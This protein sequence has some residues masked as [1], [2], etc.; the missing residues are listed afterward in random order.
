M[1]SWKKPTILQI[2]RALV[3]LAPANQK[4]NERRHFYSRLKNPT[5][6]PFLIN[7]GIYKNPPAK[8]K[9]I[10]GHI[11]YPLW[12]EFEYLKNISNEVPADVVNIIKSLQVQK[13]SKLLKDICEIASKLDCI[14]LSLSLKSFVFQLC[15][16]E[17]QHFL[18]SP[19][20]KILSRWAISTP[21]SKN[22]ALKLFKKIIIFRPAPNIPSE[23]RC[24]RELY[25][26][27]SQTYRKQ[28]KPQPIVSNW[29]YQEILQKGGRVLVEQAPF[30]CANIIFKALLQLLELTHC[31]DSKTGYDTS[32]I[33]CE[34][35]DHSTRYSKDAESELVHTMVYACELIF[36]HHKQKVSDID[37]LL[38]SSNWFLFRRIR[39]HLFAKYPDQAEKEWF[40][41]CI[42]EP[43]RNYAEQEHHYEFQR[44]LRIACQKYGQAL[45][46][47]NELQGYLDTILT[48]P[49][50]QKWIEGYKSWN[51]IEPSDKDFITR[52][53]YFHR[54][55]LRP[56]ASVLY[57][58][59]KD[60]YASLEA[61]ALKM[62]ADPIT[63][64]DYHPIPMR[65]HSVQSH[66]PKSSHDMKEMSDEDLFNYLQEWDSPQRIYSPQKGTVEISHSALSSAF[67]IHFIE[68]ISHNSNR[69]SWWLKNAKTFHRPIFCEAIVKALTNLVEAKQ[70]EQLQDV[71]DFCNWVLSYADNV[72]QNSGSEERKDADPKKCSWAS[73]RS[74]VKSFAAKCVTEK[75][76]LSQEWR[77]QIFSVYSQLCSGKD[78]HLDSRKVTIRNAHNL[79]STAINQTRSQ[80]LENLIDYGQWV[81]KA[82]GNQSE[83]PE[84]TKLIDQRLTGNPE[85]SDA[86]HVLLA[87]RFGAI[88]WIDQNWIKNKVEKIF[89]REDAELWQACFSAYLTHSRGYLHDYNYLKQE[90][91]YAFKSV[92]LDSEND[93]NRDDN[94]SYLIHKWM[95]YHLLTFYLSGRIELSSEGDLCLELFYNATQYHK[96]LWGDLFEHAGR[97]VRDWGA[98]VDNNV[99]KRVIALFEWRLSHAERK[100]I[101]E[102]V[103]WLDAECLDAEW[104]LD[105]LL[106]TLKFSDDDDV[107]CATLT[108]KL[109]EH[110]LQT[111][112]DKVLECFAEVTKLAEHKSYFYVS[113][114]SAKPILIKGLASKNL[115][116]Q[117]LAEEA[118]ENLLK[119][120]Q[121]EY[122]HLTDD[123]SNTNETNQ[124]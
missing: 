88:C 35:V 27:G 28:P 58:K 14:E 111:H 3:A 30:E 25:N 55:Q 87:M 67:R 1:I 24:Q 97:S 120:G 7:K 29:E 80:A 48:G 68:E 98:Q 32:E 64:D 63:D 15:S 107:K 117:K 106:Q 50:K 72:P 101:S 65:C 91:L 51:S 113:E 42:R 5:W 73:S 95:G 92:V 54:T 17:H 10:D 2:D 100:E 89:P 75:V 110:F 33:W 78:I 71:F 108:D 62:G 56:F 102:Y 16:P 47:D 44:M 8:K 21:R 45:F 86:E 84:V 83:L 6:L 114:Q 123:A 99:V 38:C 59:Y 81:R 13:N 74:A 94:D 36:Q 105:G 76:G 119:V 115:E 19:T 69:L 41:A 39:Q 53:A 11:Y 26:N 96:E 122:L 18:P 124:I 57:G 12:P 43:D 37:K 31:E 20:I 77:K 49:D 70:H 90:Y 85:L 52:Q 60:R 40:Q 82:R 103:F 104:R 112:P 118:R 9:T 116:T 121:F 66:S 93:K 34:R 109:N 4:E 23:N 79:V 22:E 46:N 61:E